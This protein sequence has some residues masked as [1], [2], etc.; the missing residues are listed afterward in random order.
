MTDPQDEDTNET[1]VESTAPDALVAETLA[2]IEV[3][4]APG[5][6]A[7]KKSELERLRN[8]GDTLLFD[9]AVDWALI[10][11]DGER[12][13]SGYAQNLD[14]AFEDMIACLAQAQTSD[15]DD[16]EVICAVS[17]ADDAADDTTP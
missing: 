11:G 5:T 10:L 12:R 17:N 15:G 9:G 14:E 1:T 13:M 6:V 7:A 2:R 16:G 4:F 8:S 3:A